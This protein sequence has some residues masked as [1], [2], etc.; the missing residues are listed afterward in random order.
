MPRVCS[1]CTHAKRP[2]IDTALADY[3]SYRDIAREYSVSK[4]AIMRHAQ[5][6]PPPAVQVTGH[7]ETPA[8]APCTC[9]CTRINWTELARETESVSQQMQT[10]QDP[11][12]ALYLLRYMTGLLAKLTA[13]A[14]AGKRGNG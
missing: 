7:V 6:S 1:I 3:L 12:C 11:Y 13:S 2:D 14:C 4:S 8:P 9:P 5:H 10:V